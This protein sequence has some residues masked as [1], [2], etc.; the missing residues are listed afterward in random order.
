MNGGWTARG[1][2]NPSIER[3]GKQYNTDGMA[4]VPAPAAGKDTPL[5]GS[6]L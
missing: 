5:P 2:V 4:G 1:E 6:M 3:T